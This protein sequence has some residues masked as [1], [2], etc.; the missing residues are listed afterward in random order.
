M[1]RNLLTILFIIISIIASA[2]RAEKDS[3]IKRI[4]LVDGKIVYSD[5]ITANGHTA[6]QLDSAAKKWFRNYFIY[7]DN[8]AGAPN[9]TTSTVY[10]RGVFEFKCMPGYMNIPFYGILTMQITCHNNSYSYRIFNIYF[11][12]HNGFLNAV[13]FERDPNY[14]ISLYN[15]KH[16]S[17]GEAWRVDKHEIRGY[18]V[19]V[20]GAI[21]TCI[22]SLNKAMAN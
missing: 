1:K 11:R 15:K 21:R 22:A 17:F 3:I 10:N 18:L 8:K 20:D 5:S 2:Q 7:T 19:G 12:P 9:S 14:L 4:P 6:V 13:G 16:L